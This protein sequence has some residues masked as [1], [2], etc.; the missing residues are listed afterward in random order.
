M[1]CPRVHIGIYDL[2]SQGSGLVSCWIDIVAPSSEIRVELGVESGPVLRKW[3][4]ICLSIGSCIIVS[5]FGAS[6]IYVRKS[7]V[8][9]L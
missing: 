9:A 6:N 5:S 2:L 1:L 7:V 3:A 4:A 8:V